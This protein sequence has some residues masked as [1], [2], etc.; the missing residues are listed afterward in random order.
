MI[1][2]QATSERTE[3]D[4]LDVRNGT[5]V[6]G[7]GERAYAT[8]EV[9]LALAN[10]LDHDRRQSTC[11]MEK[12]S[13]VQVSD[14]LGGQGFK[15]AISRRRARARTFKLHAPPQVECDESGAFGEWFKRPWGE[16][17]AKGPEVSVNLHWWPRRS[18]LQFT[19]G[20]C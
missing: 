14:G 8:I 6:V 4:L 2:L 12:V 15:L 7:Y 3:V 13:V 18:A 1:T 16:Q 17:W 20:I 5:K 19:F 11:R 9:C 10:D